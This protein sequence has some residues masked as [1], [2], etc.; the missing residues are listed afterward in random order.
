[1]VFDLIANACRRR[2]DAASLKE[3]QLARTVVIFVFLLAVATGFTSVA[4]ASYVINDH[5]GG[6]ILWADR[7]EINHVSVAYDPA[8]GTYLLQDTAGIKTLRGRPFEAFGCTARSTVV[9]CAWLELTVHLGDRDD[10]L[11]V[12]SAAA[13]RMVK[14]RRTGKNLRTYEVEA[15]L[16]VTASGGPGNDVLTGN[17]GADSL[18]GGGDWYLDSATKEELKDARGKDTLVGGDGPDELVPGAGNDRVE[19]GDGADVMAGDAGND[20]I[21]G[22]PGG[23]TIASPDAGNDRLLG[24]PGDDLISPYNGRDT[25]DAGPGDDRIFSLDSQFRRTGG[26]TIACGPGNDWF[27]PEAAD[28]VSGC[29]QLFEEWPQSV[30]LC[31]VCTFRIETKIASKLLVLARLRVALSERKPWGVIPL[32]RRV[33][34]LVRSRGTLRVRLVA[35]SGSRTPYGREWFVLKR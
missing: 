24:G 34:A 14:V 31:R 5:H 16:G 9:A 1:M 12:T 7:G 11:T 13:P 4:H 27:E 6:G 10:Q 32:G 3:V 25:V 2:L 23:D 28:V 35:M 19:A 33:R 26:S 21:N 15:P 18:S 29:E 30:P 20:I 22:G 8:S 17:A